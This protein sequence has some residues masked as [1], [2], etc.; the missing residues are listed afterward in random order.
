VRT[1]PTVWLADLTHTQQVITSDV[2][3]AAIGSIATFTETR[4]S[5]GNRIRLFKYPERLAEALDQE[6]PDVIGFSNY[7][8]NFRIS[9]KFAT[10]VKKF[11]PKTIV[12]FGGPNY[13]TVL[14]EQEEFLKTHPVI[15][16]YVIKEGELGFAQ[17]LTSLI[18]HGHDAEE[19]K[20]G[21]ELPS[22][23]W[24]RP[25]GRPSLPHEVARLQDLTVIPSPYATGRLDEF[26]DGKLIP[27]LQ[28]N[29][30][31]PFACTFCVEGLSYYNKV[32]RNSYE[33]VAEEIDY[34]G[35][36][37]AE[38]RNRGW[39][40]DLYISDSNFGMYKQD[41]EIC[42]AL[43][44]SMEK[45]G[46]PEYINATTGKNQKE[47]ILEAAKL[48]KGALRLSGSVQ[49]LDQEVLKN[50][51]RSNISEEQILELA[52]KASELN[53]NSYSEIILGLPG[54]SKRAHFDSV[55]TIV[56]AGFKNV[57]TWQLMLLRGSE[58]CTKVERKKY[59]MV[60]KYRTLPRC[61]GHFT[62]RSEPV[63]A[64][65][66]EEVCVANNTL[67]FDDYLACRRL[68]LV[69]GVFYNDTVLSAL[70]KLL[71]MHGIS[72]F[73]WIE[74]MSNHPV[75]SRLREVFESFERQTR[76]EL[77]DD[78]DELA[79]FADRKENVVRYING[80]I[81]NNLL[82]IHRSMAL[83]AYTQEVADFAGET[84]R[85]LL[86]QEGKLTE[87]VND[88]IGDAL[89]YMVCRLKNVFTTRDEPVRARLLYD[90]PAFE[91]AREPQRIA[92]FALASARE[93]SFVLDPSQ[94]DV[95]NR[96]LTIY[97]NTLIG[98]SRILM[99]LY[100]SKLFR[101]AIVM[102]ESDGKHAR[103]TAGEYVISGLQD[104]LS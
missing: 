2:M 44:A 59:G 51:K 99:K 96:Y 72:P 36:M 92:D 98:I 43:A 10:L 7:V 6:M 14:E 87:E 39:R 70:I 62:V 22:V 93:F 67:S 18:Q 28:T 94:E 79:D 48:V 20:W 19:V 76:E 104:S 91:S 15:D 29:R 84:V 90:I 31:C 23:H 13:P 83:T 64:S 25:D 17:L 9:Y 5:L 58:L 30:G 45:Y 33:K 27:I 46:W 60:T 4:V 81:G 55:R 57:Y 50:V 47:R 61:Y 16:F 52:I 42:T 102:D 66:I 75:E 40:R 95:I 71:K 80:E 82:F 8:W 103:Q 53:T 68:H 21:A 89:A 56:N 73:R 97:G 100:V 34:I 49:S 101:H 54:D 26:F 41:L 65:E 35:H 1:T 3:P 24:V 69:I 11:S 86:Q 85:L 12:V 88:F 37:M 63:V 38:G 77:W 78:F 32:Y 74:L